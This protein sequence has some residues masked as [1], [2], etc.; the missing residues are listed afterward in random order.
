MGW[1]G[2]CGSHSIAA[3]CTLALSS[4]PTHPSAPCLRRPPARRPQDRSV[5]RF[6]GSFIKQYA[7]QHLYALK[8]QHAGDAPLCVTLVATQQDEAAEGAAPP[9]A[10][11]QGAGSCVGTLDVRLLDPERV[12]G[13][14]WPDGVPQTQQP[15]AACE[16]AAASIGWRCRTQ[17]PAGCSLASSVHNHMLVAA[18][19]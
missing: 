10:A 9:P 13:A 3:R 15:E 19:R 12:M 16:C 1:G 14:R 8:K 2:P 18:Y 7:E 4:P 17:P 5:G 11:Q 6:K